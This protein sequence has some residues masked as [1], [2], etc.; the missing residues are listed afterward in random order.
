[1]NGNTCKLPVSVGT[2]YV[3]IN[4]TPQVLQYENYITPPISL[5]RDKNKWGK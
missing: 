2:P 1:M 3:M 4:N 5:G